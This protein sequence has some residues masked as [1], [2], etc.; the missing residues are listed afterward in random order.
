MRAIHAKIA[1]RRKGFPA[2]GEHDDCQQYGLDAVGNVSS[3]KLAKTN[4]ANIPDLR[5]MRKHCWTEGRAGLN[6][7]M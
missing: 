4:M 5:R 3:S 2:R 1:N 7:R 6:K